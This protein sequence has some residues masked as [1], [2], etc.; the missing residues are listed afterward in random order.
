MMSMA[1]FRAW[2]MFI[3]AMA[4]F[5]RHFVA[6]LGFLPAQMLGDL[7]EDVV[8]HEARVEARPVVESAV[9]D[10]FLPRLGDVR[11]EL[12]GQRLVALLRPFSEADQV[13]LEA[14]DR[15]AERELLV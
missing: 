15:V 10:R 2:I 14:L 12:G 9:A 11:L 5:P 6:H 3:C 8:E 4:L 13:R 7:A 1:E